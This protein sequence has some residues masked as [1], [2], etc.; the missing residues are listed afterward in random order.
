MSTQSKQSPQ[1]VN[2]WWV[3]AHASRLH[4]L[5][6]HEDGRWRY[7]DI[8]EDVDVD[9]QALIEHG[10]VEH[11][12]RSR[13]AQLD[14]T[15]AETAYVWYYRT[16]KGVHEFVQQVLDGQPTLPCGHIGWMTVSVSDGVYQC[17]TC[18]DEYD[19]SVIE[20]VHS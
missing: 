6:R 7:G 16:R 9:I 1:G 15:R 2:R 20:G 11:V 14:G 8:R 13:P 4:G 5:P 10:L 3:Y 18:G 12:Q 19:R 17:T